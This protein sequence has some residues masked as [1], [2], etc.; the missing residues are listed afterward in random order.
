[1]GFEVTAMAQ[2][3]HSP[4]ALSRCCA[5]TLT[6]G[7]WQSKDALA[8]VISCQPDVVVPVTEG[9]LVR[10]APVRAEVEAKAKVVAPPPPVLDEA[11]DKAFTAK[12]AELL[13]VA[14]PEH[15]VLGA[16][17]TVFEVPPAP[18]PLVA[19][20]ARSR[21]LRRD[22]TV[23]GATASWV[24]DLAALRAVHAA[25]AA[26]DVD[27][28]VQRPVAGDG[29]LASVLLRDDG[30]PSLVFV[31]RRVR[32]ARPEGGP[33]ACAVSVAPDERFVEPAVRLARALHLV[34]VPV[35]FEF[36]VDGSGAPSLLDV[37]PRPW[38]TLGLALDCGVN[39]YGLA[40]RHAAGDP[41]PA[42]P[43]PYRA[44]VERHYLP[45]ELRRAWT[46]LFEQPRAGFPGPWP[47]KGA[48]AIEWIFVPTDGL[49]GRLDDPLPAFGD[50][51][52][53]AARALSGGGH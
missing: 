3:W 49:V 51:V 39:F 52:R 18:F 46:V 33:S 42:P 30:D 11:T 34:G 1:M 16:R 36:R 4:A 38:G 6:V 25:N 26:V 43:P 40:A 27:T 37:N 20:P 48:A 5:R 21:A 53:L 9:D 7:V 31:H 23:W 28:I 44:G 14:V 19:K 10:L 41:L 13:G 2:A 12:A 15:W 47:D 8:A 24:A 35:Q 29:V 22:G 32:E 45:F 17:E 50:A